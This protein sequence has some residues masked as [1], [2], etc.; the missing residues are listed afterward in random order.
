M[1][2]SEINKTGAITAVTVF[3]IFFSLS[4]AAAEDAPP[5][6]KSQY[7]LFN[8]VPDDLMRS[9][10]TDRPTKSNSPYTVDAGHFQYEADIVNWTYDRYN[11]AHTTASNFLVG[12]PTLKVGLTQNTD[13]EMA[14]AL[15][16]FNE[17]HNRIAGA[18]NTA[19][20]FGDVFG[21]VK[22]NMFGND[23]GDYALAITPYVKAPTA[24]HN[25]GND[26]WEGGGY[27]PFQVALPDDWSLTLMSQLDI[28]ENAALNGYH[29]NYQ[30]LVN[31]SHPVFAD[32]V[33]GYVEFWSDVDNDRNTPPQYTLD[34]AAAWTVKDN[35]QLDVGIN[36]GLNKAANDAQPYIGISQRF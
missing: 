15:I 1:A 33:T 4:A 17:S 24:A 9:F 20:G 34:F 31:I 10:S 21:R 5:P 6:D 30:N 3:A 28:L 26:H 29:T 8:P 36:V 13:F 32:N 25:V 12:D 19:S 23:G 18:H 14:L 35:L 2:Q 22:F 16:N 7:T 11:S 27:V